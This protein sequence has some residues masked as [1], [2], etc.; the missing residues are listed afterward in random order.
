M[1]HFPHNGPLGGVD[2]VA[3]MTGAVCR[4]RA[5]YVAFHHGL[6]G[7]ETVYLFHGEYQL[8]L[9]HENPSVVTPISQGITEGALAGHFNLAQSG[10]YNLGLTI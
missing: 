10:H 8:A 4:Y 1:G 3:S 2:A 7:L 6:D 5:G 9:C